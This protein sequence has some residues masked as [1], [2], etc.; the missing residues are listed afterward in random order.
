[1][2]KFIYGGKEINTTD[3]VNEVFENYKQFNSELDG[4]FKQSQ[5]PKKAPTNIIDLEDSIEFKIVYPNAKKELFDIF[6]DDE[7]LLNVKYNSDKKDSKDENKYISKEFNSD[8]NGFERKYQ[9]PKYVN[10]ES[11]IKCR[12]ENGVLFITLK[13]NKP[14]IKKVV[15]D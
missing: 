3:F 5:Q 9:L 10:G 8:Y 15:I 1:M 14:E 6:I 7:N 12:Y 2:I 11:D 4:H 13:K